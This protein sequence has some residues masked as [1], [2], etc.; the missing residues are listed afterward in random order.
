MLPCLQVS[1]VVRLRAA[2]PPP[3]GDVLG[4]GVEQ[5]ARGP[6]NFPAAAWDQVDTSEF[7]QRTAVPARLRKDVHAMHIMVLAA[8][9]STVGVI[10][11]IIIGGI[12]GALAGR[13]VKGS[14]FGILG[15]IIVGIVGALLGGFLAGLILSDTIGV[16]GSF[17]LAFV[18]AVVLLWL[19]RLLSGR[20]ARA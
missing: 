13:V 5:A 4:A 3:A 14:G 19:L 6:R 9:I 20:R 1:S 16:I 8:V 18:G 11:W 10:G 17:I 12:A 2:R 15:D 7:G